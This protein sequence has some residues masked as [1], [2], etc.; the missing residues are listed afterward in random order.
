MSFKPSPRIRA[1]ALIAALALSTLPLLAAPAA[2]A[3]EIPDS[4]AEANTLL[5]VWVDAG[6]LEQAAGQE[7]KTLTASMPAREKAEAEEF[8]KA[9]AA[10]EKE[11]KAVGGEGI[12]LGAAL[13]PNVD[14][15]PKF[16][17]LVKTKAG[18]DRAQIEKLLHGMADKI[19][20]PQAKKALQAVK[21]EKYGDSTVWHGVT[22]GDLMAPPLTGNAKDAAVFNAALKPVEKAPF[23]LC[24]RMPLALKAKVQ[25]E[26][27][28]QLKNPDAGGGNPME[29][30]MM[31]MMEPMTKLD[32]V[33][34]SGDMAKDAKNAAFTMHFADA[35]AAN[36]F[37]MSFNGLIQ[38]GKGMATGELAQ[39]AKYGLDVK[40]ANAVMDQLVLKADQKDAGIKFDNAFW[41]KA[42]T[43]VTQASAA[44]KKM[45]EARFG[46]AGVGA[47][48]DAP[49]E[50]TAL[51]PAA[52]VAP[53]PE[54]K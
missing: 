44:Q 31:G 50:Q 18:T 10:T 25:E 13:A 28:R 20:E 4:A 23:Q 48:A 39:M 19:K 6:G 53:A 2:R 40:N 43:L 51:P 8:L 46:G 17:M 35:K 52:P 24:F 30:M 49:E 11:F 38:M 1:R 36:D 54:E 45:M 16:F 26:M 32:T 42:E 34:V 29:A 33:V 5:M 9:F 37:S 14:D 15:A 3:V 47:D 12:L 7:A 21:I 41:S 27:D 22:A